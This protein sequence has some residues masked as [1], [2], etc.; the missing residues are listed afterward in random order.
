M[1]HDSM[2]HDLAR[3]YI[4][5]HDFARGDFKCYDSITRFSHKTLSV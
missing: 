1:R 5:S 4:K 3:G 2:K